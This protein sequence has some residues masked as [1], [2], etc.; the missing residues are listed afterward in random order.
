VYLTIHIVENILDSMKKL[1]DL[2]DIKSG[3]TFRT[4]IDSFPDGDVEVIQVGDLDFHFN[5]SA[6]PKID[7]P[8]NK[9]HLLQYGDILVSARGFSKAVVYRSNDKA[10]AASSLFVLRVKSKQT[11]PSF[12]AMFFN[13]THGIKATLRLSSNS[14]VQTITKE[15]LGQIELPELPPGKQNALGKLIQAI[16]DYQ[17]LAQAKDIYLDNIRSTAIDKIFKETTR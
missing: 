12:I 8:G 10:V 2:V 6:K 14:S 4:A 11:N 7:F 13:S 9:E 15:N 3:Y 17:S 16:D 1:M 5:F